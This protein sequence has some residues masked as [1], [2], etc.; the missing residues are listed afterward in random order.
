MWY[1]NGYYTTAMDIIPIHIP[2]EIICIIIKE[3]IYISYDIDT[4]LIVCK[5]WNK[6][7]LN[8][9][10]KIIITDYA[11]VFPYGSA[12]SR[13]YAGTITFTLLH[14]QCRLDF[15]VDT[16]YPAHLSKLDKTYI[17]RLFL[18]FNEYKNIP[19]SIKMDKYHL[20]LSCGRQYSEKS[21]IIKNIMR[22]AHID[23]LI[24]DI[25]TYSLSFV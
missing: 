2:A 17:D 21:Q 6:I 8:G 13:M 24:S 11:P 22:V 5:L 19:I 3:N 7:V 4:L 20:A 14:Y 23:E 1:Y 16:T 10:R 9:I 25:H 15:K 18:S 12:H